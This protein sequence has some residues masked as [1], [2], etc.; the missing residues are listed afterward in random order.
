M[1]LRR[2]C[3]EDEASGE[4]AKLA[5]RRPSLPRANPRLAE[6]T[7]EEGDGQPCAC[8]GPSLPRGLESQSSPRARRRSR[9]VFGLPGTKLALHL[10]NAASQARRPSACGVDRSQSPL[11]G[12]SGIAPDSRLSLDVGLG[13][14]NKHNI[15]VCGARVKRKIGERLGG[16][17]LQRPCKAPSYFDIAKGNRRTWS[18]TPPRPRRAC[19][20]GPRAAA[21]GLEIYMAARWRRVNRA[22]DRRCSERRIDRSATDAR[23]SASSRRSQS[24]ESQQGG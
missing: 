7:N 9:Q 23:I 12:S 4:K 11:R 15:C 20:A 2:R 13:T 5:I 19:T 16:A 3:R 22:S 14:A 24:E 17:S 6:C 21:A 1:L 10:L 8:F 18:A